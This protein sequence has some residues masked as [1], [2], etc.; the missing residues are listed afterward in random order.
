MKLDLTPAPWIWPPMECTLPSSTV[1]F[2]R[3]ISITEPLR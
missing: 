3:D 2:R 1:L